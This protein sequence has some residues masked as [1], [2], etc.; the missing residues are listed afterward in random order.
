M[1]SRPSEKGNP[2]LGKGV[3]VP[4]TKRYPLLGKRRPALGKRVH[5]PRHRGTRP[6]KK[7]VVARTTVTVPRDRGTPVPRTWGTRPSERGRPFRGKGRTVPREEGHPSLVHG[8]PRPLGKGVRGPRKRGIY[9]V[10]WEGAPDRQK[11][12]PVL[13]KRG[14]HPSE[15]G[16]PSLGLRVAVP[17]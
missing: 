13:R 2:S 16:Y 14:T 1:G 3:P 5:G 10:P 9:T 4:R 15:K 12:E 11:G 17:R 6:S 8:V 7:P